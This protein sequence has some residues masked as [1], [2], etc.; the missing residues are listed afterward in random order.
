MMGGISHI[1]GGSLSDNGTRQYFADIVTNWLR[2]SQI[3]T[4]EKI[5]EGCYIP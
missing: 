3:I 1:D 2:K 4:D 5:K